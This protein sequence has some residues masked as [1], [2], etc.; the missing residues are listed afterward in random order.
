MGVMEAFMQVDSGTHVTKKA[1]LKKADEVCQAYARAATSSNSAYS[2]ELNQCMHSVGH[3][4]A[5]VFDKPYTEL[6]A[7]CD[8]TSPMAQTS[9]YYGVSMEMILP[10]NRGK[11]T[12]HHT[13]DPVQTA[14]LCSPLHDSAK[15]VACMHYIPYAWRERSIP[16]QESITLCDKASHRE[17]CVHSHVTMTLDDY[18]AK[19]DHTIFDLLPLLTAKDLKSSITHA[20]H[21]LGMKPG[22]HDYVCDMVPQSE[23]QYCVAKL[24][25]Q[26]EFFSHTTP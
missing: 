9:C 4:I 5:I 17:A 1:F 21:L 19:G 14:V 16:I 15:I 13:T 25:Q 26:K 8:T 23:K 2:T 12:I 10:T 22:S 11:S 20:T 6:L 7:L 18:M 24:H 3:S